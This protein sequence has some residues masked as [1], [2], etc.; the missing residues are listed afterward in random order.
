MS[1]PSLTV[2]LCGNVTW[3]S[4]VAL[5]IGEMADGRNRA[6]HQAGC[7]PGGPNVDSAWRDGRRPT[8]AVADLDLRWW[9]ASRSASG[10][11]RTTPSGHRLGTPRQS[12]SNLR[13]RD[14]AAARPAAG[15]AGM[16]ARAGLSMRCTRPGWGRCPAVWG[17]SETQVGGVTE[18]RTRSVQRQAPA[19]PVHALDAVRAFSSLGR[20]TKVTQSGPRDG[21]GRS[22]WGSCRTST[23]D[24]PSLWLQT[25]RWMLAGELT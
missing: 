13:S 21:G 20:T 17:W 22:G 14:R 23:G 24:D 18:S 11:R 7:A 25:Q 15:T 10:R 8:P 19:R 12:R 6:I 5:G 3:T 4:E 2:P 16:C 9:L 1:T